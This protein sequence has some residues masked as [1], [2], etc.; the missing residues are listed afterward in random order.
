[1]HHVTTLAV[2]GG[3]LFG[4]RDDYELRLTILA[5]AV[6]DGRW[7]LNQFCLM[8]NHEHLLVTVE[9]GGLAKAMQW[10]NRSY[11]VSFN[12]THGRRG[13]LY[14]RRYGSKHVTDERHALWVV[15]YIALNPEAVAN[16][17]AE[18]YRWSSYAS[19]IGLREPERFVNDKPIVDFF[20][21]GADGRHRI[22]SAVRDA[23]RW[24]LQRLRAEHLAE[25]AM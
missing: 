25:R 18:T 15:P 2:A 16:V 12:A 11:A 17:S 10:V 13:C 21:G 4:T 3:W 1:M 14:G 23:R 22:A 20:G 9:T 5:K 24:Q 7:E 19:L 8:G 6:R